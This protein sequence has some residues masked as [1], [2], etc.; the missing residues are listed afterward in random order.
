MIECIVS[1]TVG[2]EMDGTTTVREQSALVRQLR[3]DDSDDED[4]LFRL[5]SSEQPCAR[6]HEIVSRDIR[7]IMITIGREKFARMSSYT[8]LLGKHRR[9]KID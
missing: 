2:E 8:V 6:P 5:G 4:C 7:S 9:P 1:H 3:D